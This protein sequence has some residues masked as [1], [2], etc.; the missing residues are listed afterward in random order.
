MKNNQL[1]HPFRTYA[2]FDARMTRVGTCISAGSK[3]QALYQAQ[4]DLDH[5]R[6]IATPIAVQPIF[7]KQTRID[8]EIFARGDLVP[9]QYQNVRMLQDAAGGR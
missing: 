7:E 8:G 5:D 1:R 6:Y 3:A 2:V 9:F 4:M